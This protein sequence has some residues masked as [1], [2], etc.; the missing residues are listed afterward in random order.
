MA[1]FASA[2]LFLPLHHWKAFSLLKCAI[3]F[4]KREKVAEQPVYLYTCGM[5]CYLENN[6]TS[7]DKSGKEH[8]L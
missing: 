3:H 8:T 1:T 2:D 6:L 4:K 5:S 7:T